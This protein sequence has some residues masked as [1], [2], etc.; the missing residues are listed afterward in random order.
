MKK[1]GLKRPPP[2]FPP[3]IFFFKMLTAD[4]ILSDAEIKSFEQNELVDTVKMTI[5]SHP[6]LDDML[7]KIRARKIPWEVR[8]IK[9]FILCIDCSLIGV[10]R[11]WAYQY[12]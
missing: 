4:A 2:F 10:S 11:C 3:F 6:Y 7:H 5:I 8:H 1:R 12:G 9:R